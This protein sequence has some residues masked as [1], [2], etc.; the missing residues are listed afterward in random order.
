MARLS[1]VLRDR[2][3]GMLLAGRSIAEVARIFA[4]T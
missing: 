2:A 1:Q 3:V 4:C